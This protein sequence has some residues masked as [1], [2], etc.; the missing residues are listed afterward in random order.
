MDRATER[1]R[2]RVEEILTEAAEAH[3]R[4]AAG[5]APAIVEAAAVVSEALRRGG[6]VLLFGNGGSAA[7]AQHIAAELQG[8]LRKERRGLPALALTVNPS[9]LT[10]LSNDYG[11]D[12]VF[13]RQVEAL[14]KKGDVAIGISTS[15]A[16]ASVVKGLEAAAAAGMATI[17]FTGE[18]GGPMATHCDHLV[19]APASDTQRIQEIHITVGHALAELVETELFGD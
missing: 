1:E 6:K 2:A 17:G 19:R 12:A 3:A 8:R 16:S 4:A 14:G 11:Y 13:A 9:V 15:G 5:L 7:D 18:G 10:A